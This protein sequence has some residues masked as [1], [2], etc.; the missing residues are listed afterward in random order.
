MSAVKTLPR[1]AKNLNNLV[2]N[3]RLSEH[4]RDEITTDARQ[5]GEAVPPGVKGGDG[6]NASQVILSHKSP[7]RNCVAGFSV[8][9]P[10]PC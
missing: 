6:A 8:D 7:P 1:V 2:A 5:V 10:D 9:R 4:A 3:G